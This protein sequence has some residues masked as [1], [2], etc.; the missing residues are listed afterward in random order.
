MDAVGDPL[1]PE[2]VGVDEG[3]FGVRVLG[4]ILV[5]REPGE[6]ERHAVAGSDV[7]LGLGMEVPADEVDR[8]REEECI[9]ARHRMEALVSPAH[10]GD[11]RAIV[12]PDAQTH[13]HRD[14]PLDALDDAHDVRRLPARRHEIDQAHDAFV[15]GELRLEDERVAAVSPPRRG[16]VRRGPERPSAVLLVAEERG[17]ARARVEARKA[18]PVDAA[19][20]RDERSGLQVADEAVVLDQCGHACTLSR[21]G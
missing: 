6:D 10:P 21:A 17:E 19:M 20:T 3:L 4:Q 1:A 8:R 9:R 15:A 12:E 2:V 13:L 11:D 14:S 7:E 18:E 16:D 5:G